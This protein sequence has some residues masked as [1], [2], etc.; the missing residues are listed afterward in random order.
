MKRFIQSLSLAA[1]AA[2]LLAGSLWACNSNK[3]TD[4]T[5][6]LKEAL[7]APVVVKNDSAKVVALSLKI[8]EAIKSRDYATLSTFVHD[9]LGVRFSPYAYVDTTFHALIYKDLLANAKSYKKTVSWGSYDGSGKKIDLTVGD[10]FTKF[11]WDKNYLA[12]EKMGFNRS[13]AKGN[14][15]N[16]LAQTYPNCVFTEF[17]FSG[18]DKK[19]E[20]KDWSALRLVFKTEGAEYFLVG[21]IHDQWTS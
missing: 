19:Y 14:A 6:T 10:Y 11:V 7:P 13:F 9:S 18:A 8:M 15:A 4:K 12:A 2:F 21:V 1:M 20:G 3:A 5:T 17:Y 16:N